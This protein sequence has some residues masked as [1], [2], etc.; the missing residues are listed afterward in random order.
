MS[1]EKLWYLLDLGELL[2]D[3]T[4][5]IITD[6]VDVLFFLLTLDGFS[7]VVDDGIGRN[8]AGGRRVSLDYLLIDKSFPEP[9]NEQKTNLELDVAHGRIHSEYVSLVKRT[10]GLHEVRLEEHLEEVSSE[11]FDGVID[12]KNVNTLAI[13]DVRSG[14]NAEMYMLV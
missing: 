5:V 7:F 9:L 3:T 14:R 4:D 2:A 11:S 6:V 10:V 12:G 13:G 8:D 1:E